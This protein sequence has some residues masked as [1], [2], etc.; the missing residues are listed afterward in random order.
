MPLDIDAARVVVAALDLGESHDR[1]R[2]GQGFASEAWLVRTAD[3]VYRPPGRTGG[4]RLSQH[5][6]RRARRH[7]RARPSAGA[8]VP[9]PV[10][11][12]WTV[13]DWV[14]P[15]FS[16]T[17]QVAGGLTPRTSVLADLDRPGRRLRPRPP[18]DPGDRVRAA[19]CDRCRSRLR[20]S[21]T[22][23]P[24]CSRG[25]RTACGRSARGRCE[26]TR[27]WPATRD[28]AVSD[29]IATRDAVRAAMAEGP[30]VL[31]HSDLHEEN[32]LSDGGRGWPFIDFG[33]TF[34]GAA[35]W[36]FA[37]FAY[38]TSWDAGRRADRGARRRRRRRR[39]AL[40]RAAS[41]LALVVGP[42]PLGAGPRDGPRH[43]RLQR[44][45]PAADPRRASRLLPSGRWRSWASRSGRSCTTTWPAV[46]TAASTS[47]TAR[48][49]G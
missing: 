23:R 40:R 3:A 10:A 14:G 18:G 22:S 30:F 38:F 39:P 47:S 20:W 15:D 31:V 2:S 49:G 13:R 9:R 29:R 37:T 16:L 45:L 6:S 27:P 44:G 42:D 12:S 11:G 7:D 46:A 41:L 19:R 32:I 1:A 33:E 25:S 34:V 24:G 26:R 43:R 17:T 5:L 21:R 36:E 48:P 4:R 28:L 8:A 35:A